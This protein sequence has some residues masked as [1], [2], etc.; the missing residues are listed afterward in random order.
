MEKSKDARNNIGNS[1]AIPPLDL[2]AASK[3]GNDDLLRALDVTLQ[4]ISRSK[5]TELQTKYGRNVISHEKPESTVSR[6][7]KAFVNPFTMVLFVLVVISIFT[8]IIYA[9]QKS[10]RTIIL[11]FSMVFMSGMLRFI[12][13]NR[14]N[15][16]ADKLKAMVH[17]TALVERSDGGKADIP[18]SEI[19]PG[20]IVHLSAGDMIPADLRFVSVKDL[21][22]DQATLTAESD[23]VEK[24]DGINQKETKNQFELLNIG[25]M[26]SYVV[27]GTAIGVVVATGDRTC[28]GSM[29]KSITGKRGATSFEK[30]INSVSWVLVRFIVA[31]V[32]VVFF[33]NGFTKGD[34]LEALLFALSVAVGVTPEMLPMIVTT[35]L[36]KGAVAM[37]RKKTVVKHLDSMQN[38]GAM[39][40]LCT[41]KTGTLTQNK[42]VLEYHLNVRGEEDPRVLRHAFFNSYFQTGLKNLMDI[43]IL[44]HAEEEAIGKEVGNYTKVDEIPFDFNRRRMSVIIKNS[45]G[46][47]QMIT[48][49]AV[50]EMLGISSSAEYN[51]K[52]MELTP[53]IRTEILQ[54]VDKLNNQGMRV[55]AVA[56]KNDP[57]AVGEF[58]VKDEVDMTFMGYV[59][60]LDPPKETSKSAIQ[61][62]NEYGITVKILTGDNDAISRFICSQVG[63]NAENLL[64]G[65]QIEQMDDKTLAVEAEKVH[66]F[67]KLAPQQKARIVKILRENG[68]VVGFLGDGINDASAMRESDVAISVD[69][70]VDIA[71]ESADIILLEKDLKVLS[72]GVIEGRKTFGN[73]IKYIKM[74]ASSNFGNMFSVVAAS[75]FLPFLPMLPIQILVLNFIYDL[76][77]TSIPW[78]HMDAEYLKKPRKWDASSI[79]KFMI[80]I[81]PTSSVFDVATYIIMF[82][83]ICPSVCGGPYGAPG[84]NNIL[85]MSLFNAG[86]FVESLWSQTLVIHMIRTPKIPFFQSRA[87]FPVLL[88]TTLSITAGTI[89]PYTP[90]GTAMGMSGMPLTYFPWLVG[91][92]LCYMALATFQKT[93]FIRKYGELL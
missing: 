19:V 33:L 51:G 10:F 69:T 27:S 28:F 48:K 85:F 80:W 32:P 4:G 5:A 20:D 77:C 82:F 1:S 12:Q 60:F 78:D 65:S 86:W 47:T 46:Q 75:A 45:D 23:P 53:E 3:L 41:D 63:I 89:I 52:V 49:G 18:L 61:S 64:L 8:D 7:I 57:S 58:S 92:I 76:S 62:L 87:S 59:A 24:Y 37:S 2:M 35:N 70:A 91:M 40:I 71:K 68:H 84:V 21:F 15:K 25:F 50:E 79:G 13:E 54:H 6:L 17:T 29:A 88:F 26:G 39:D 44:S 36:A 14:S 90:F 81:G 43:A 38:F 74:T 56:Q 31:M 16:A 11:I 42:V 34:W 72:D 93:M 9:E 55:L 66:V 22:I 73:I 67:A 30:G 83:I